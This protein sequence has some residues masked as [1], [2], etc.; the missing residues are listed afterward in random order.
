MFALGGVREGQDAGRKLEMTPGWYELREARKGSDLGKGKQE[1][2]HTPGHSFEDGHHTQ[3]VQVSPSMRAHRSQV[4]QNEGARMESS[5]KEAGWE[6]PSSE[7]LLHARCCT[8]QS[9]GVNI[10][11]PILQMGKPRCG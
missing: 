6:Q 7:P 2:H 11:L 9:H 3:P 1:A 4:F 8:H 5:N 10:S